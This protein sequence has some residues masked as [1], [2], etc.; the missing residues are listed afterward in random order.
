MN[1]VFVF[2]FLWMTSMAHA[3]EIYPNGCVPLVVEGEYVLIPSGG[4]RIIMIHNLSTTDLWITHRMSDETSNTDWSSRLQSNR[5]SA[6]K[7]NKHTL[8][9][10][11]IESRPGHEQQISC[12][13]AVGI[14]QWSTLKQSQKHAGIFWAGENRRLSTLIAYI[15]RHGFVVPSSI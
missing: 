7:L 11:C 10:S 14:C 5:W 8:K 15:E 13:N 2:L 6:L 9:L 3:E 1:Y 4:Q 12:S